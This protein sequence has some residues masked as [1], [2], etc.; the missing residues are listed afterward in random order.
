MGET[1]VRNNYV[2]LILGVAAGWRQ[3]WPRSAELCADGGTSH[4]TI[5]FDIA[6]ESGVSSIDPVRGIV[7]INPWSCTHEAE[8]DVT[9][10]SDNNSHVS[11][12]HDQVARLR[13]RDPLKPLDS[14]IE[15]VGTGVGI[16]KASTFVNR[17]H[18]VRTVVS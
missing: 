2:R 6:I 5:I 15:I 18:K 3:F 17:M 13:V 7:V 8:K 4:A 1:V 14:D 10:R 12:P 9:R 11:A 16:R